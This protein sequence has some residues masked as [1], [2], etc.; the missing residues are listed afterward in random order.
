MAEGVSGSEGE[1]KGGGA[2]PGALVGE[3]RRVRGGDGDGLLD[4]M[5]N[6]AAACGGDPY[7]W[8]NVKGARPVGAS[9][10]T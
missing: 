5:S 3:A 2:V 1:D 6:A 8:P 9:R 7:P 10:R 4:E